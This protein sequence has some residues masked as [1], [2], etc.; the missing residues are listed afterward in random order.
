MLKPNVV[1][2]ATVFIAFSHQFSYFMGYGV[3]AFNASYAMYN[4]LCFI[5]IAYYFYAENKTVVIFRSKRLL[6]LVLLFFVLA[7]FS[8]VNSLQPLVSVASWLSHVSIVFLGVSAFMFVSTW[9]TK[10][11]QLIIVMLA[12]GFF[13]VFREWFSI[14]ENWSI[15]KHLKSGD[16]VQV[17]TF[18]HIRNMMHM[19]T[20]M[21]LISLYFN[22]KNIQGY[23]Y[24]LLLVIQW[25]LLTVLVWAAGRIHLVLIPLAILMFS[26]V[27]RRHNFALKLFIYSWL[28]V[29]FAVIFLKLI[30]Q[31][32]MFGHLAGRMEFDFNNLSKFINSIASE[33]IAIIEPVE[34][35]KEL[36][37][38]LGAN[39]GGLWLAGY[40]LW[41]QR[42]LFGH[43]ADGYHLADDQ[44]NGTHPHNWIILLLVQYGV[45]GLVFFATMLVL[46]FKAA[47]SNYIDNHNGLAV[48]VI[49]YNVVFL[50]YGLLS[51]CFYYAL[52]LMYFVVV[53]AIFLGCYCKDKHSRGSVQI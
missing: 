23:R 2:L 49:V 30:G 47:I 51:G 3:M 14:Y 6:L 35:S 1:Y 40:E 33:E 48:L 27:A 29:F 9:P 53:N 19:V 52:P 15:Y 22:L 44:N 7:F 39:R 12:A 11:T 20:A 26:I 37:G 45:V 18:N 43:G 4:F 25:V 31:D 24:F 34:S 21:W 17:V 42:P 38:R 41:Q 16:I 46:V 36:A 13:V 28:M 32:F 8:S 50:T 5:A 10:V